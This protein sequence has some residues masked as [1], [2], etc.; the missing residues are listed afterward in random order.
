MHYSFGG[1]LAAPPLGNAGLFEV[2]DAEAGGAAIWM[3]GLRFDNDPHGHTVPMLYLDRD[4]MD[5]WMEQLSPQAADLDRVRD[6]I[7]DWI[8][9]LQ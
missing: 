2:V 8:L 6:T 5:A 7:V 1:Q 4:I 9:R 3:D